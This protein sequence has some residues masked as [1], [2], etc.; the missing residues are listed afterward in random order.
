MSAEDFRRTACTSLLQHVVEVNSYRR[1]GAT[2]E[3]LQLSEGTGKDVKRQPDDHDSA[4]RLSSFIQIF[5][6]TSSYLSM[7][8]CST[9]LYACVNSTSAF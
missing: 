4:V 2:E 8:E 5:Q 7:Q 9:Q 3:K 6:N 1:V